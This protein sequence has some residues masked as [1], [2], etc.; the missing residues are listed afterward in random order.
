VT[1]D[2]ERTRDFALRCLTDRQRHTAK[3]LGYE[4]DPNWRALIDQETEQWRQMIDQAPDFA[5]LLY[6]LDGND[7]PD[8]LFFAWL[9]REIDITILRESIIAVWSG[10]E[11]PGRRVRMWFEMFEATGS[12]YNGPALTIY[13]GSTSGHRKGMAWTTDRE[14][15]RWFAAR[16]TLWGRSGSLYE[17]TAPTETILA[18]VD[19]VYA[20]DRGEHEIIVDPRR[21]GEIVR[22]EANVPAEAPLVSETFDKTH[23]VLP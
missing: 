23:L 7:G 15:A 12:F 11:F 10:A 21:L 14:S 1:A 5:H 22:L 16:N 8:L 20:G 2:L 4:D 9:W 18:D 6:C 19:A 3:V 17:T 13:R